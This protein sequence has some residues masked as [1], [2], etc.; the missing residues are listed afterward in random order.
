M[1]PDNYSA[2]SVA[3]SFENDIT[4]VKVNVVQL[5]AIY[6]HEAKKKWVVADK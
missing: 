6:L 2:D 3:N 5:S 1:L 4:N